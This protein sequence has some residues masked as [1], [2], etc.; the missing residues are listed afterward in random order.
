M[1]VDAHVP[2]CIRTAVLELNGFFIKDIKLGGRHSDGDRTELEVCGVEIIKIRCVY[3][4]I[5]KE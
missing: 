2:M 5:L 1:P 4:E 3:N